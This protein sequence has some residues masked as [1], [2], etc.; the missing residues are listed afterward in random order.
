MHIGWIGW[1][2]IGMQI[3]ANIAPQR[4]GEATNWLIAKQTQSQM[5]ASVRLHLGAIARLQNRCNFL[6]TFAPIFYP[7]SHLKEKLSL[8]RFQNI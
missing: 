1:M 7:L 4:M 3:D 6:I 8:E 5:H 2:Y